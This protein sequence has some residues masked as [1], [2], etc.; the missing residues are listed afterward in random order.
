MRGSGP[1]PARREGGRR[2]TDEQLDEVL[3][4][5]D[6]AIGPPES[7]TPEERELRRRMVDRDAE[8]RRIRRRG[9]PEER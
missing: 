4:R 6:A 3:D 9:T 7:E 8:A 1:V 2:V 5:I